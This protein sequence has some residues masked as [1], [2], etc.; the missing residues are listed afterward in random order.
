MRMKCYI[1]TGSK[2]DRREAFSCS[3]KESSR[4]KFSST[5]GF[6]IIV[7]SKLDFR[8]PN[9]PIK[10]DASTWV[11]SGTDSRSATALR[12][13]VCHYLRAPGRAHL[14]CAPDGGLLRAR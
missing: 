7:S 11:N 9:S 14:I 2:A 4:V 5:D 6:A 13:P 10:L 8:K 1:A 12:N 3:L